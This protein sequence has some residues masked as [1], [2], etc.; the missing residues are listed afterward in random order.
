MKRKP[1]DP[2][3]VTGLQ[4]GMQLQQRV[5][6]DADRSP[7][8]SVSRARDAWFCGDFNACLAWLD[9]AEPS[10][11]D[12]LRDEAVLL[13]AR[14]LYRLRR[15]AEVVALLGPILTSF[16]SVDEA[17]TARM[18]HASAVAQ[19]QDAGHGLT[20]LAEVAAAAEALQAHPAIRGEIAYFRA[21]AHWT[22]RE[23]GVALRFA[24]AAESVRADVISAR[25]TQLRGFIA[26]T[27]HRYPEALALFR[28]ALDV[29]RGCHERDAFLAETIVLQIA[30]L[31][32]TL[33][34]ARVPGTHRSP[35]G[36][37]TR[38]VG[39]P[40]AETWS[41]PRV[42]TAG[43]DAWLYAHDGDAA[44][45]YR[46][47][48]I[49][50]QFA[51]TP[52]WRT[53]ALAGRAALAN[54]FGELHAAREHAA[55]AAELA[56]TIDW[57]A[58]LGEERVALLILAEVLSATDPLAALPVMA[59][60]EELS[61]PMDRAQ[62][63]SDDPRREAL[64]CHVRGLIART[65][66]DNAGARVLLRRAYTICHE[67]GSLSRAVLSLVEL[68][69]T[70][71]GDLGRRDF[72]LESAAQLV[73]EH[74]PNSFLARRLGSW[75]N[76]YG[77]PVA[78]R[79]TRAQREILRH[80]LAGNVPKEIAAATGRAYKTVRNH[81]EAIEQLFG[82]HSVPE[83]IVACYQRGLAPPPAEPRA[84]RSA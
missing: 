78:A 24:V 68:D 32:V 22:K 14:S 20:L 54:A 50:E 25:A 44:N 41:L 43:L 53:W 67:C 21:L 75:M 71:A 63:L 36:R 58:T 48:R 23:L 52:A 15:F 62:V 66:G 31:E 40:D 45:A 33:R 42:H 5:Q 13:R 65:R 35:D 69:A 46:H 7:T 39:E 56:A 27:E 34:S 81:V 19:F 79:L 76:A 4:A 72:S 73:R 9:G 16:R 70:P 59:R 82:V 61:V 2:L 3:L 8:V 12:P 28:H 10:A 1:A 77:D 47:M 74:F 49:A 26:L 18:L 64:E 83:L 11:A 55:Q 60:Y 30:T 17:C 38:G 80:L 84:D 57:S 51:P 6:C 29:Y 37:R